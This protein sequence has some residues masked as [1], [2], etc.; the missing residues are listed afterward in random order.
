MS[1][2]NRN[3]IAD[4]DLMYNKSPYI[5]EDTLAMTLARN[6]IGFQLYLDVMH[7]YS[8]TSI[9]NSLRRTAT[10]NAVK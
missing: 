2:F 3:C 1:S 5:N 10:T 4:M 8:R 7:C 6:S 9:F